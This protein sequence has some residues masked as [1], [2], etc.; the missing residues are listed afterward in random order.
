[1]LLFIRVNQILALRVPETLYLH[2][3]AGCLHDLSL[4]LSLSVA[5]TRPR[6]PMRCSARAVRNTICILYGDGGGSYYFIHDRVL[7][8]TGAVGCKLSTDIIGNICNIAALRAT[9]VREKMKI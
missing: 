1:M 2:R 7:S 8:T 6:I 5:I 3:S 4:F 9:R